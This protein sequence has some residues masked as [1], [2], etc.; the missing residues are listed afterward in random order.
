MYIYEGILLQVFDYDF[1]P[2][3]ELAGKGAI[4][5]NVSSEGVDDLS[6]LQERRARLRLKLAP[7]KPK[8]RRASTSYQV[9]LVTSRADRGVLDEARA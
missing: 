2:S 6:D 8:E 9:C 1:S 4:N 3:N 5:M 7:A